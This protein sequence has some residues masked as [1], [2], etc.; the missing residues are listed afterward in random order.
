MCT[1]NYN[2]CFFPKFGS[3]FTQP[4]VYFNMKSCT[5]TP[6]KFTAEGWIVSLQFCCHFRKIHKL[7]E[8]RWKKIF[9]DEMKRD[10]VLLF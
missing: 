5:E 9:V 6:S 3:N 4:I 7:R 10:T 2:I 8:D 1:E